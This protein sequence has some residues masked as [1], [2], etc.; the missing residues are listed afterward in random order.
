MSIWTS[1]QNGKKQQH[2]I[3]PNQNVY[4]DASPKHR[5]ALSQLVNQGGVSVAVADEVLDARG[6]VQT[7]FRYISVFHAIDADPVETSHTWEE[8][9]G[10]LG[11]IK[12]PEGLED[13]Y[14]DMFH[15]GVT[16]TSSF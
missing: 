12:L 4:R 6:D 9:M 13:C 11:E 3:D 7:A 8:Y 5:A 10:E 15:G 16:T 2:V 14:M 1:I